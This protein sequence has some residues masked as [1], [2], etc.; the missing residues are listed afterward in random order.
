MSLCDLNVQKTVRQTL[1]NRDYYADISRELL[2]FTLFNCFQEAQCAALEA[3]LTKLAHRL[4]AIE[5]NVK[6]SYAAHGTNLLCLLEDC[7]AASH[8]TKHWGLA[9]TGPPT[10]CCIAA[11]VSIRSTFLK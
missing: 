2:Q 1:T 8:A 5:R 6:R 11:T 7:K 4:S 10:H 3:A 9:Q